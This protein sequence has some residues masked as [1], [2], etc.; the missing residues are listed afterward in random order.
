[1]KYLQTP[2]KQSTHQTG[3]RRNKERGPKSDLEGGH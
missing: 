2:L 1:M 3:K